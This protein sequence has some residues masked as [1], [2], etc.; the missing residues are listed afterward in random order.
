[1]I[2]LECWL[3]SGDFVEVLVW[4]CFEVDV[5]CVVVDLVYI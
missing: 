3:L 1:M 4:Y 2:G 5:I